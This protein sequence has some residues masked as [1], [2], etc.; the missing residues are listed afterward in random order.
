MFNQKGSVLSRK[1][2]LL[3]GKISS[4]VERVHAHLKGSVLSWIKWI[5]SE[6][7][8]YFELKNSMLS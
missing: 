2:G 7:K 5:F 8:F 1:K 6:E 4:S 3:P